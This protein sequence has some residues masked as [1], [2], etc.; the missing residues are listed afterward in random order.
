MQKFCSQKCYWDS[1]KGQESK[2][3]NGK[4]IK[5]KTCNL[6]FYISES[7]F[8]K[9]KYCSR[10]CAVKDN[11]G[12]KPKDKKCSVCECVFTIKS[13]LETNKKTCSHECHCELARQ[14][15]EKRN[16]KLKQTKKT[17]KCKECKNKFEHNLSFKKVFCSNDC[18]KKF[19]KKSR[20]GKKNPNYRGG[21]F[22]RKN[23]KGTTAHK[24]NKACLDYRKK[25]LLKHNYLFCEI[26]GVNSNGTI[27]HDVHHIYFASKIPKHKELHNERNLIMV[28]RECHLDFH[29]NRKQDEFKKL[30]KER[31]LKRLFGF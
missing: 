22:T 17:L 16:K 29:A 12:F 19:L 10:E 26:C 18:Q 4:N 24:H 13:G 8:G 21:Y 15:T 20:I 2:R 23:F 14:I 25:F 31:K 30:Q 3:K 27:K 11:Y 7:R 1:L 6:E 5:C 9:K 28:C